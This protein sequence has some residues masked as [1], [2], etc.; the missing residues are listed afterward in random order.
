VRTLNRAQLYQK[1]ARTNSLFAGHLLL[2]PKPK[3]RG[4]D[5]VT[6]FL[7][8]EFER[9][10]SRDKSVKWLIEFYESWNPDCNEFA[11]VFSELSAK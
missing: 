8:D 10:L 2:F 1:T 5:N 6:Y 7:G 9:E 4:P 11:G 3:Y